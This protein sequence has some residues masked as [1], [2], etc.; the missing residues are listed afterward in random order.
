[1]QV[2]PCKQGSQFTNRTVNDCICLSA[3]SQSCASVTYLKAAPSP[4]VSR[5]ALTT[6]GKEGETRESLKTLK[7]LKVAPTTLVC[8]GVQNLKPTP[9]NGVPTFALTTSSFLL[10]HHFLPVVSPLPSCCLTTSFLLSDRF[11]PVV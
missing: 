5:S 6:G 10:S 9:E 7:N 3:S 1:M 8:R 2:S 11:L 4:P